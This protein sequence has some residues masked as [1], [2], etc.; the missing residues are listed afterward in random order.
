MAYNAVT[1]LATWRKP[2][3]SREDVARSVL[4]GARAEEINKGFDD[5][6]KYVV[7]YSN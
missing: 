6:E 5:I 1:E 4:A 3:D 7:K 2:S